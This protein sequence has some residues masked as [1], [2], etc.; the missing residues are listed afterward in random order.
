M[1]DENARSELEQLKARPEDCGTGEAIPEAVQLQH[2]EKSVRSTRNYRLVVGS[3]VALALI[4]ML[5]GCKWCNFEVSDFIL[6]RLIWLVGAIC[7][8]QRIETEHFFPK[9]RPRANGVTRK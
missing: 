1:S 6:H 3:L 8:L 5:D 9:R 7:V 2:S 4:I